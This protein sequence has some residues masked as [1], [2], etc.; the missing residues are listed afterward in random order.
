MSEKY[1]N[2]PLEKIVQEIQNED[3][4]FVKEWINEEIEK[5]CKKLDER[6]IEGHLHYSKMKDFIGDIFCKLLINKYHGNP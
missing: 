2:P 6:D 5:E 1:V 4:F 3:I